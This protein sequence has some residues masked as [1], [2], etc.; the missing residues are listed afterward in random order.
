MSGASGFGAPSE[1]RAG[2]GRLAVGV[3]AAILVLLLGGVLRA[4][5]TVAIP[6]ILAI[7]VTL[8]VLP[9]DRAVAGRF[10]RGF[11]WL[12]RAAVILLL[13]L[14]LGAFIGG[15]A[16]CVM[17][18]AT[19][20]QNVSGSFADLLPEPG[21]SGQ[22][23]GLLSGV[24]S[25]IGQMIRD[26]GDSITGRLIGVVTDLAQTIANAMGVVLAGMLFV[27]FLV[28]LALT[29]MPLWE[30]KLDNLSGG[31]A[32]SWRDVTETMGRAL[33]RF[34]MTRAAVGV[35][36][37]AI[38]S[39]WLMVFGLDLVVVWAILTFLMNFIPNLGAVISGVLPTLYA[40][41]TLDVGTALLIGAGLIAIE[42]VI[43]SWID[44]R[45]QGHQIA[46]SPTVI[47]TAVLFWS[48]LWGVAGA[49]LGTPMTLTIM[50]LCNHVA[51][52]RPIALMLSNQK[53]ARDLDEALGWPRGAGERT[54][55][56]S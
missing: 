51:A 36:S 35:I 49:F 20:M 33:R 55:P 42:Q 1:E 23:G 9:L 32:G 48:W 38:Y 47:L 25:D 4:M 21:D 17:R 24:W 43:G 14:L 13:L 34:F 39:A 19:D 29:E 18:I 3:L 12:G 7:F 44:P 26:R 37:A 16:Y 27:L 15:L 30:R 5:T 45:L 22:N 56:S 11:R 10:P 40:F 28:L 41:F 50:I 53:D 46:L 54:A 6:V 8:A 2:R 52:S 31:A